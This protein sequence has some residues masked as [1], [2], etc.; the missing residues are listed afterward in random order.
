MEKTKGII[1]SVIAG[2]YYVETEGEI[3]QCRARGKLR[4]DDLTPMTGD[5]VHFSASNDGCVLE[6]LLPRRNFLLRPAV[7]NVD[8][9]FILVSPKKPQPNLLMVDKL[10]IQLLSMKIEPIICV[11]KSDLD[12]Q[13]A[14]NL[15]QLY[16][17]AGFNG[18]IC[19]AVTGQGLDKLCH[20]AANRTIVLAGQ[21]GVG[22]SHITSLIALEQEE[23]PEL[24][25][26]ALGRVST[27]LKAH[28]A[29]YG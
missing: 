21:S 27:V 8:A 22:K 24:V 9:A 3:Y 5:F 18:I 16:R 6:Q 19:S 17:D 14:Q 28:R 11:N 25:G 1:V 4:L 29:R 7:A 2:Y 15:A 10:L 12:C 26:A 20:L 23:L 13:G